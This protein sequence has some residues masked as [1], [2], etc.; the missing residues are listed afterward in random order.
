MGRQDR[1]AGIATRIDC[2]LGD[3]F[4]GA[5]QDYVAGFA[6][7]PAGGFQRGDHDLGYWR[8]MASPQV[9]FLGRHL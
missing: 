6:Q 8:R 7:A 9:G 1:L 3:P 5:A 4:C 2:G